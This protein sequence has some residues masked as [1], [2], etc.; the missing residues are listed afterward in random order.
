MPPTE[1]E[2]PIIII[3]AGDARD[4]LLSISV[5]F[6]VAFHLTLLKNRI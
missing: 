3:P 4:E 6:E 2:K 1:K 5:L